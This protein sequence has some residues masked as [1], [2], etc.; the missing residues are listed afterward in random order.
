[1]QNARPSA[2]TG[3]ICTSIG[4]LRIESGAPLAGHDNLN[5]P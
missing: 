5:R 1:M 2:C 3:S 4:M